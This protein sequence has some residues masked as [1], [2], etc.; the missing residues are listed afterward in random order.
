[1]ASGIEYVN[2]SK[3]LYA[4]R[5]FSEKKIPWA[6]DVIKFIFLYFALFKSIIIIVS[7]IP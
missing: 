4:P 5:E 2:Q 1:V 6:S 7:Y 3:S